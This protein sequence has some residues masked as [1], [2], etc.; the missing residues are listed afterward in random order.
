MIIK[1]KNKTFGCIGCHDGDRP[2]N[3]PKKVGVR[4][5]LGMTHVKAG[6]ML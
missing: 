1:S 2:I 3:L 6:D 4:L 5:S